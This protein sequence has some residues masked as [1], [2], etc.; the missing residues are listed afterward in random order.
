MYNLTMD[1]GDT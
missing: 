1:W